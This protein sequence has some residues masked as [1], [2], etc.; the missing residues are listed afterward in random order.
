[1]YPALDLTTLPSVSS[2]IQDENFFGTETSPPSSGDSVTTTTHHRHSQPSLLASHLMQGT[3]MGR[4]GRG[5]TSNFSQ[6]LLCV[7]LVA[8]FFINPLS[9]T[10]QHLVRSSGHVAAATRTL[11]ASEEM[12]D[13]TNQMEGGDL[14]TANIIYYLFWVLRVLI[15]AGCFGYL[16]LKSMPR[17]T[18][19]SSDA[20]R[21]WRFRKQAENDLQKVNIH[22]PCTHT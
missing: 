17:I 4:G 16:T 22:Q 3:V 10:G 11:S 6:Y 19:N 9:F 8:V 7:L 15:A 18:A 14:V 5:G 20:V 1:L 12:M 2:P 21:F 13:L